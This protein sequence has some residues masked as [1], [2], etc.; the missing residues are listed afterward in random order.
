[1]KGSSLPSSCSFGSQFSF[2]E[3]TNTAHVNLWQRRAVA[4]THRQLPSVFSGC[5][6][7][8][9]RLRSSPNAALN[10][11]MVASEPLKLTALGA[12]GV[13][14]RSCNHR[15]CLMVSLGST[16]G[17]HLFFSFSTRLQSSRGRNH[18][19]LLAVRLASQDTSLYQ[20]LPAARATQ[21]NQGCSLAIHN[22][23]L[24]SASVA[25]TAN[26]G[27]GW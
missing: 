17:I 23:M 19:L 3:G 5:Q 4:S 11:L 27:C 18:F 26:L 8:L 25:P 7:S 22:S 13:Q 6:P 21:I 1:M 20:G 14:H 12:D 2:S 10:L 24:R 9:Q 15:Y 16:G